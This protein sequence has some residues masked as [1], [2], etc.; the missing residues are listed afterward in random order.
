MLPETATSFA[1]EQSQA[2]QSGEP[3]PPKTRVFEIMVFSGG[4]VT[5]SV[6][7]LDYAE[8]RHE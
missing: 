3:E 4:P 2:E 1:N 5:A 6:R 7:L 8:H